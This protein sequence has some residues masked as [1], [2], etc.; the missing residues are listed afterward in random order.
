MLNDEWIRQSQEIAIFVW[1]LRIDSQILAEFG[2]RLAGLKTYRDNC[3]L[4]IIIKVLEPFPADDADFFAD[5]RR[6]FSFTATPYSLLS[7]VSIQVDYFFH[8]R[9]SAFICEKKSAKICGKYHLHFEQVEITEAI[10]VEEP[11]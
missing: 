5:W 1:I 8:N 10:P 3:P 2:E 9:L 11:K 7:H 6:L 4:F